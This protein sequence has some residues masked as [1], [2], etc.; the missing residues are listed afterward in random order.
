MKVT[1][2]KGAISYTLRYAL[3]G[4]GGVPGPWTEVILISPKKVTINNL[5][6]GSTYAFQVRALGK[7]GYSDWSDSMTFICA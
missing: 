5:T 1:T 2:L 3:V 7:L 4:T 6:P